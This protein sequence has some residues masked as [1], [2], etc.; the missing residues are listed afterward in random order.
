MALEVFYS[1]AHEDERLRDQLDKHLSLL[2]RRGL[3]KGWHDREI[4]AGG[5]WRNQIDEHLESAEIILLLVSADFLASD[6]IYDVEMKL[7]LE[8]H[9][10]GEAIVIPIILRPVSWSG[11]P[12]AHLKALPRDGKP[13]VSWRTEDDAFLNISNE[14]EKIVTRFISGPRSAV[15]TRQ[16]TEPRKLRDRYVPS[17]RVLDAA[18][19]SH[20]VKGVATELLALIRLP[21]SK[22]LEG[23]LLA[24]EEAEAKPK[25]V[26][27]AD[28]DVIFP[29]GPDGKPEPLKATIVLVSPDF[30]P[31][32][33]ARNVLIP[34]NVD[35]QTVQFLLIPI[36]T[37]RLRVLIE[38]QWEEVLRGSRRL[39]TECVAEASAIPARNE[40]N[41]VQVHFEVGE[42]EKGKFGVIAIADYDSAGSRPSRES[43]WGVSGRDPIEPESFRLPYDGSSPSRVPEEEK[44]SRTQWREKIGHVES[45]RLPVEEARSSNL[46]R[47]I[48]AIIAAVPLALGAYWQYVYKPGHMD[49]PAPTQAEWVTFSG[50][51]L[52]SHTGEFIAH[53]KVDVA[54]NNGLNSLA[55]YTDSAGSFS[56]R[57]PHVE[58]GAQGTMYVHADGFQPTEKLFTILDSAMRQDFR[59]DPVIVPTP[60]PSPQMAKPIALTGRLIDSETGTGISHAIV[61]LTGRAESNLTDDNGNFRIRLGAPLPSGELRLQVKKK[62]CATLDQAVQPSTENLVLELSCA[63][64]LSEDVRGEIDEIKKGKHEEMPPAEAAEPALGGETGTEILNDTPFTLTFYLTG[65]LTQRVVIGPG[66]SKSM[67]VPPGDYEVAVRASS[68][69]VIPYYGQQ[70]YNPNT[71]YSEHFMIGKSSV[72]T[73]VE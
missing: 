31:P 25:D 64:S 69:S 72:E 3:I 34:P 27:G 49:S 63:K 15:K 53:A 44:E 45:A 16:K 61:S 33:Q 51:V 6:Y 42:G 20:I 10:R 14:I 70:R 11:A 73:H 18:I 12:F 30:S 40:K 32:R 50:R 52:N 29:V 2:E 23:I 71:K 46:A 60:S 19:P 58:P 28:F 22:G 9:D 35:S 8:R 67:S 39:V 4:R 7:A 57:L 21:E 13:I 66:D 41:L 62:G 36:R 55:E 48:V 68:K 47:I 5:E 43:P 17:P 56:F 59:L 24:D 65:P 54:L 26:R 38:L 37:G 1:Y